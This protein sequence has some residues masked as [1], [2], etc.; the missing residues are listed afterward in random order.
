M[1]SVDAPPTNHAAGS[2][3]RERNRPV[4]NSRNTK[5]SQAKAM[6]QVQLASQAN[7]RPAGKDPGAAIKACS[8]YCSEK[9]LTPS[10]K[11]AA[12][13]SQP[14]RLAGRREARTK[15]TTGM[16]RLTNSH[17]PLEKPLRQA[18]GHQMAVHISQRQRAE[19]QHH[20]GCRG[21]ASH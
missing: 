21:T 8:P 15:P 11:A 14:M 5:A 19:P 10:A 2:H 16:A 13:N 18:S 3:R 6:S 7:A 9:V 12:R 17:K 4:G 1:V 20:R